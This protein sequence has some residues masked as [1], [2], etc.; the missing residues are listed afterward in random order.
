MVAAIENNRIAGTR[1]TVWDVL[2]YLE[3]GRSYDEIAEVLRVSREQVEAAARHIDEHREY[4]M[5]VHR[6]IEERNARGNPPE[7]LAK[8]EQTRAK[9]EAWLK[10]R[11]QAGQGDQNGARSPGRRE[12]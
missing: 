8:L 4:V 11:R 5:G 7:I 1:I 2:H 3:A 12:L 10:E 6:Q 9:M